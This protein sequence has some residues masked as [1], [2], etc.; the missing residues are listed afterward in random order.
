MHPERELLRYTPFR[1]LHSD[2]LNRAVVPS[3]VSQPELSIQIDQ[4]DEVV[5]LFDAEVCAQEQDGFR[6]QKILVDPVCPRSTA[7]YCMND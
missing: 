1:K 4:A 6:D 7:L 5:L 2:W 3:R